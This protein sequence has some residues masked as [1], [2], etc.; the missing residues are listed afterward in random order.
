MGNVPQQPT[1]TS[2]GIKCD[3]VECDFTKE[4]AVFE[5]Y[6]AYV[7]APCPKCGANL[8][9]EADYE[10]IETFHL[11]ATNEEFAKKVN[12]EAQTSLPKEIADMIA[13]L[14]DPEMQ[15]TIR[16]EFVDGMPKMT[17]DDPKVQEVIDAID[18]HIASLAKN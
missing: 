10:A 18:N 13:K 9:T 6:S 3:A 16:I 12:T 14:E 15:A 11:L 7:N 4:L 5:E 8:L 2:H 17:S 1:I